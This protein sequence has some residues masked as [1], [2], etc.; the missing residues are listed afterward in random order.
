MKDVEALLKEVR[1]DIDA[2]DDR[3]LELF[4]KRMKCS[5]RVAEIKGRSGLPVF[6]EARE[7]AIIDWVKG[8]AGSYGGEA[9]SLYSAIMAVS[10]ERQYQMLNEDDDVKSLIRNSPAALETKGK[11]IVCQGVSGAYSHKAARMF[12]G[13]NADISFTPQFGGV[14]KAVEE[15][16]G[17]FGVIPMENSAAGSVSEVYGL[18]M[19]Y[20]FYICGAVSLFVNHC[21]CTKSGAAITK[22]FSHP[23]AL[24]QCSN[25]IKRNSLEKAEYSNTAAAAKYIAENGRE[26][27]AVIC[28]KEAAEQ[29]GLNVI[30]EGIQDSANNHTRFAVVSKMPVFP[31]NAKKISLC[32]NLPNIPGSL[33]GVLQRFAINGLNLTKIESRPLKN[34]DFNYEFYLDFTGS[35]HEEPVLNLISSLKASIG[36][37][38]FLGNYDEIKE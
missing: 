34:S 32:F 12:F 22:V 19:K 1:T 6:N 30:Q 11:K 31:I 7:Q 14:F 37:F 5:E 17:D 20:R 26:G 27:E 23:Q 25:Y 2:I 38:T 8:R 4:V 24:L 13:E 16:A 15:G 18:M 3:L 35:I 9:A 21:I 36:T 10:R 33:S 29:Y 28:S